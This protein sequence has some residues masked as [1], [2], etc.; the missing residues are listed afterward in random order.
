MRK[1]LAAMTLAVGLMAMAPTQ[2]RADH[3]GF[4]FRFGGGGCDG[5]YVGFG[6]SDPY[7]APRPS[8]GP[9]VVYDT[10]RPC[11]HWECR[12]ESYIVTCGFWERVWVADCGC[13]HWESRWV[14]PVYGTRTVRVWVQ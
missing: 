3:F 2:A 11:G 6:Y 13:G 14:P 8:C 4:G 10:C 7:C 9:Y 1:V 5:G 12:T